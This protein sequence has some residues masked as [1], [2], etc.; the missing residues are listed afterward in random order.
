[1]TIQRRPWEPER[2]GSFTT[3]YP[4]QRWEPKE[5]VVMSE[6]LP[7]A[8][9]QGQAVGYGGPLTA[10]GKTASRLLQAVRARQQLAKASLDCITD[11]N[12]G[13]R[14]IDPLQRDPTI[15]PADAGNFRNRIPLCIKLERLHTAVV[16]LDSQNHLNEDAAIATGFKAMKTSEPFEFH[17]N[18]S[19]ALASV[20]PPWEG[21]GYVDG[22]DV[23]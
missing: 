8:G 14:P 11:F 12:E 22:R 15:A 2:L 17:R 1:V 4:P 21:Q 19:T 6:T 5:K 10:T 20:V 16:G 23:S 13:D 3:Y 7:S 18:V 9:K